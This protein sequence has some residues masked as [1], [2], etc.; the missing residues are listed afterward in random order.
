MKPNGV[1]H[2]HAITLQTFDPK[3]ACP[4]K[5]TVF[6]PDWMYHAIRDFVKTVPRE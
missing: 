4:E 2:V 6:I 1:T 3:K 5:E